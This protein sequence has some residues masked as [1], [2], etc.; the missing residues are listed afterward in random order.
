MLQEAR[1]ARGVVTQ[2]PEGLRPAGRAAGCG[3][4]AAVPSEHLGSDPADDAVLLTLEHPARPQNPAGAFRGR[5]VFTEGLGSPQEGDPSR[6]G[7]WALEVRRSSR[8]SA[9]LEP[10]WAAGA[11]GGGVD[12]EEVQVD[13]PVKNSGRP[14][15][16]WHLRGRGR[17]L[18]GG[19]A[20]HPRPAA[21]FCP[22]PG[23]AGAPRPQCGRHGVQQRTAAGAV[24]GLGRRGVQ[25]LCHV[26]S[27]A[28]PTLV[29]GWLCVSPVQGGRSKDRAWK[30][31]GAGVR[32][33]SAG[34]GW[35][36]QGVVWCGGGGQSLRRGQEG[37]GQ[38]LTWERP[39]GR[40]H[41]ER[42]WAGGGG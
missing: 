13:V 27:R 21:W 1:G 3:Q 5:Q 22:G 34:Q 26:A 41:G 36:G 7:A 8:G 31:S 38:G 32:P 20:P 11:G 40:G 39:G 29:S 28:S 15:P 33:R 35:S 10:N 30:E 17:R 4:R 14:D 23:V 18:A 19:A 12:A 37:V 2:T 6:P 16:T 25:R 42:Q 9:E 24:H